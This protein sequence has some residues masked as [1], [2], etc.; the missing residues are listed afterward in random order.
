MKY[1]FEI[2]LSP[3]GKLFIVA[4]QKELISVLFHNG[5]QV[6]IQKMNAV[7]SATNPVIKSAIQ[8]L[9]E[10]FEKK[11]TIFE[12]PIRLIGTDFQKAVWQQLL[13]IPYGETKS[14]QDQA[15]GIQKPK[16]VRAVG[17]TNGL[18]PISIIVPCHR[19]IGKSGKLTGYAGGL[20]IKQFLLSHE[21][22]T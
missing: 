4:T 10:Y 9:N 5:N 8:Q 13:T 16:A 21:A 3:I 7:Q 14:Y 15:L 11:R 6:A 19:V 22:N 18:N 17:R 20:E 12:L 2:M 1:E